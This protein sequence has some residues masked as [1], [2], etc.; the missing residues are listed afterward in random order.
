VRVQ[1]ADRE[2]CVARK[3]AVHRA[4]TEHLPRAARR[5]AESLVLTAG[6]QCTKGSL[7][8]DMWWCQKRATKSSGMRSSR[9]QGPTLQ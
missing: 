1:Q 4:L 2:P 6:M 9:N 3:R 8:V 5:L 7:T